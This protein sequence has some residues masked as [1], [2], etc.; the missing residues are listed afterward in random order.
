[1]VLALQDDAGSPLVIPGA[2]AFTV[3]PPAA[4]S[5]VLKYVQIH[6]YVY[7]SL[8]VCI[9]VCIYALLYLTLHNFYFRPTRVND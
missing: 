3:N 7:V 6:V 9:G 4:R 2:S 8:F 5:P 1:M